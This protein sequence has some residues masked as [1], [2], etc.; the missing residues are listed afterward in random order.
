MVPRRKIQKRGNKGKALQQ[1]RVQ[2]KH[3]DCG[4]NRISWGQM[5]RMGRIGHQSRRRNQRKV[6]RIHRMAGIQT[7][8]K[9]PL[10]NTISGINI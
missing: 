5:G 4:I 9:Q 10:K 3:S 8:Y 1:R 7:K 6:S 2:R